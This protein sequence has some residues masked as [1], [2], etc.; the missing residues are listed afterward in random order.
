MDYRIIKIEYNEVVSLVFPK[1]KRGGGAVAQSVERATP[2]QEVLGSITAVAARSL[3][4]G[5]VSV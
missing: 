4:V 5:A 2:G 1:K 3:L